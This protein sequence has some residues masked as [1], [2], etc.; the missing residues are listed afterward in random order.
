ML[1]ISGDVVDHEGEVAAAAGEHQKMPDL[2]VAKAAREW[3]GSLAR[4]DH[5]SD[6]VRRCRQQ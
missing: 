6:G 3:V 5:G 4:V 2:V 1:F